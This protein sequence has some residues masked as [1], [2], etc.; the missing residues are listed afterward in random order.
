MSDLHH[1]D[2]LLDDD[3]L[4]AELLLALDA[5]DELDAPPDGAAAPPFDPLHIAR[6]GG[7]SAPLSFAQQ[8]L[9]FFEQ[10]EP[11]TAFFNM[12]VQVRLSGRLDVAAL[13]RALNGIVRRHEALRSVFVM[14]DGAPQQRIAARLELALPLVDLG[15]LAPD[16]REAQARRL[17]RESA[18]QPFDLGRGPL[19]RAGLLRLDAQQHVVMLTMHHIISDGWSMGVLIREIAALYQ[20][21]AEARPAPLPELPVQYAD[22]ARWQRQ[23]LAGGVLEQQLDYWQRQLAGAPPLLALP[24]DRPRPAQQ[25]Y[26]GA[27]WSFVLPP[28]LLRALHALGG[29]HQ[30][31]LFMTLTAA[32]N[33]LLARYSGQNDICL[34]TVIANRERPQTRDLIGFFV[35]TLVLR[36]Q[37]DAS[38]SFA[39]LL[40][41]V[42]ATAL[43]AYAH[44][45]VPFEQLVDALKPVRDAS[46]APLFQVML[47]LQNVPTA[48]LDLPGLS[49][50]PVPAE[51]S[52][53][54]FDLTLYLQEEGG[55][56]AGEFEYN[57]DLFDESS[58]AR[59]A[60]H[61]QYLLGALVADPECAIEQLPLCDFDAMAPVAAVP[62]HGDERPLSPHQ[63]RMWFI[64]V[65]EAG[66]LYPA[67]P[68]YHNIPLLLEVDGP[69]TPQVLQTALDAL[70]ARHA[71]LRT[72]IATREARGWQ[73]IDDSARLPLRLLDA[74]EGGEGGDHAVELALADCA[75]P[76]EMEGGLLVRAALLR[77]GGGANLLAVT[78]HHIIADRASMR[79]LARDLVE[80]CGAA[81]EGRAARLPAL[82]LSHADHAHWQASRDPLHGEALFFYWQ[83]QLRGRLQALELPLNRPRPAV[84]TFTAARH[85]F[86]LDAALVRRLWALAQQC[87]ASR[88]DV[89]ACAF[90]ALMRR[91][92]GHAE[93]VLGTSVPAR[94]AALADT[95]GPLANL[96]VLRNEVGDDSTFLDLLR[97]VA[98]GRAGALRH[99]Q[100]QFDQLALRLKPEKDMSRT[101]LFD[102]L[103]QLEQDG[104]AVLASGPLRARSVE[105]N[106]GYGKNDLHL[107]LHGDGAGLAGKLVYNA[108]FF[109]PW[110]VEQMMGHYVALLEAMAD[111]PAQPVNRVALLDGH[112]RQRQLVDWND[113]AAAYPQELTVHQLFEQQVARLPH[114][115]ALT[116]EDAALSYDAL[117]RRANR[118]AHYLRRQGV[119]AESL[120]ALCLERGVDMIVAMLAVMKAGGAYVPVDP[121]YPAGRIAY[122]LQDSG[123]GW[124]VSGGAALTAL[125]G[126]LPAAMQLVALDAEAGA[127]DGED[128]ANPRNLNAPHHLIYVIYTSGSTGQPKGTLLEHRNVVR[129]LVN[130]R[131]PFSFGARDVWSM[132]HSYAFDFSVWEMYGALLHGGRVALVSASARR[133]PA[134]LLGQLLRQQVSV[135]NQTPTA[136]YNL[137]EEMSRHPGLALPHLRYV[138]FGGEAL[139]A[140]KL[141]AFHAAHPHVALIN[142]YGIT[143]TCVH[144][145]FKRLEGADFDSGASNI[146]RPIPTT[147]TYIMDAGQRLLPAGVAGEICVA[148]LGVG[149]GYLN[150]E[151]LSRQRFVDH[152]CLPGQRLYR[153]G[154]LG[155]LLENGEMVYLGRM[156]KQVQLRGFRVELG[157]IEAAL[158]ALPAVRDVVVCAR[159]DTPGDTRL[160]AYL[161][162]HADATPGDAQALRTALLRTLPD[163][164][165]P[166]HFIVL[167]R[168]PLT[169][170]G[171]VDTRALPAP[172]A[173][174]S[175]H[176]YVAPQT[177][178]EQALAAIW[179]RVLGL[180]QVGAQDNFFALGGHSLLATQVMS[181]LRQTLGVELPLR[182]MFEASSVAAM[183]LRIAEARQQPA[184]SAA[185]P[186][187]LARRDDTPA[188]LSFA[189]Q[190]LWFIDQLGADGALYNVPV[191]MRLTGRLDEV[192]LRRSINEIVRRHAVLRTSFEACDG[193]AVQRIAPQLELALAVTD[194]GLLPEGAREGRAQALAAAE[195]SAPFDLARGP[196][197]RA[198]LLRL[199]ARQHVVLLTLHHGVS[200][201]WS[202]GV[203]VRELAAL[204]AA[205]AAGQPSPLAELALQYADFAQWQR[206]WLDGPVLRRQLDYWRAQLADA[207]ALL[208]LPTDRPRPPQQRHRGATLAFEV[209]PATLQALNQ[210]AQREGATLFML[211]AA[212]FGALLA[213]YSGQSDICIGTPI[214]NRNRAETEQLIGFFVNTL[215]LRTR[216]EPGD[217]YASL[218][219]QVRETALAAYAHQDVP[220]EQLVEALRPQRHLSHTPLFQVMLVLQ[221]APLGSL[222]LPE[223]A[224]A[225]VDN[226]VAVAKFDLTLN[227]AEQDGRLLAAF[228]Y[229]TDLFDAATIERMAGHFTRLLAGAVARPEAP[230]RTL[231]LPGDAERQRLLEEWN[232]APA[233]AATDCAQVLFEAQAAR[234]PQLPALRC[235]ALEL[236]YATLNAS[237]N[238]L[239]RR[240]RALGVGP[241]TLV[242][243]CLE[244][245]ADLIVALLAILKAGGAYVPLDPAYPQERLRHML[246]DAA[247][248]LLLTQRALLP[249]LPLAGLPQ[250]DVLCLDDAVADHWDDGNLVHATL[251]GHL[252]YVIYTSGSSGKPKGVQIAH[253][254]LAA[255][256]AARLACYG[257]GGR[258]LLTSPVSFDS[259][260]AL[261]FGALLGGATLVLT[262]AHSVRDPLLLAGLVERERI[263]MLLCVPSLY[264]ELLHLLD[265]GRHGALRQAIVA[266]EACPPELVRRSHAL[267]PQVGLFNEYGPTEGTVW[268]TVL[269]ATPG[270]AGASVPIGRAIAGARVYILDAA[271]NPAPTGV[272]GELYIGGAG[273]ARAYLR[274]PAMSAEK[275]LPDPYAGQAGARMY[276]SGDLARYLPDG[277]IDYLG[278]LDQ[279]VKIRGFRIELDEIETALAALPGVEA[280]VV[281]AREDSH[282]QRRLVAYLLARQGADAASLAP[283]V[284][285]AA[286]ARSLPDYMVP[287]H[288]VLL[289]QWPL[290]P[291]GKLDRLALPAPDMARE[292]ASLV[293]PATAQEAMLAGL[294]AEVLGL[295]QAG[296][297]DNFFE[298]GG[299]SLLALRLLARLRAVLA[300]PVPLAALFAAPTPRELAA[301][302]ARQEIEDK[303][304][305]IAIDATGEPALLHLGGAPGAPVVFL[306]HDIGGRASAYAGMAAT[307]VRHGYA[308]AALQLT[309]HEAQLPD[310]F[311]VLLARALAAIRQRQ[312]DGPYRLAGHSYGGVLA[313]HVAGRL[314]ALGD[315]VAFLGVLDTVPPEP[316]EVP[317]AAAADPLERCLYIAAA[318]AQVAGAR[319]PAFERAAFAALPDDTARWR[320]I[321]DALAPLGLWLGVDAVAEL[322]ALDRAFA[323]LA[324]LPVAPLPLLRRAPEVWNCAAHAEDFASAWAAS[325]AQPVL[326]HRC[327]GDHVSMLEG[328]SGAALGAALAEAIARG[329]NIVELSG[330][331]A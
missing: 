236:D 126:L 106:L 7:D 180:D 303:L 109:D 260:V 134:L 284:L 331:I 237:A 283:A 201:G 298:L 151:E 50:R 302:L 328:A 17:L 160:A 132:L 10:L 296:A 282:G 195:A 315:R 199:D 142:M 311:E 122:M 268:A 322:A 329:D 245:S 197:I 161:V 65:F 22:Y 159:E 181:Q 92:A 25:R 191:A 186:A 40:R 179:A 210:L 316:G 171:K 169:A 235:G 12:P 158:L 249:A 24:T 58:V 93:I 256:T 269:R 8:R 188:P 214:A 173:N 226:P 63:E 115:V 49:L 167:E 43:G 317:L 301:W 61:F 273:V 312:P 244:R 29:A 293:A 135:L 305:T 97:G 136:F 308:V 221:N 264:A 145:T 266:G 255:S 81:L 4:D 73:R 258:Y 38:A 271:L 44:Q 217:S 52:V 118:L 55:A 232:G 119:G 96:L 13:D 274:Q 211:L 51:R 213:R 112:Q 200:D 123:S 90:N 238:R 187:M 320:L 41:Q 154:D 66:Y 16:E 292:A 231:A 137:V 175:Q 128:D 189:Q 74:G 5:M 310:S 42:R 88:F 79:L 54:K 64:D 152:P 47:L 309:G 18:Q 228:E 208:T 287:A 19:L 31:T 77:Q 172:D 196:L 15:A 206:D 190:R 267:L 105:T 56:L 198:A 265:P 45:D 194:L 32:F 1:D 288:F 176:R 26:Q 124:V 130:E 318:C 207:P 89:V 280:G 140:L 30:A 116:F 60:S 183:A 20:A 321:A 247:P 291:N 234:T 78:A 14:H 224:L 143:E 262:D 285:R 117:N 69:L 107:C 257:H 178:D 242:G 216:I 53:A 204:Y 319:A 23:W 70:M 254:N 86:V 184:A 182:V 162:P 252:A 144:V 174:R 27:S 39:A 84:H 75:L 275:F 2:A 110:L 120:V 149:R 299:H 250:L 131:M 59:M 48:A 246:Q 170:N 98:Q 166:A 21:F 307:L 209:P 270:A 71:I 177:P 286:L 127:I 253:G 263:S 99:Q 223:L 34:G 104:P 240:L 155:K 62:R 102:V 259:S 233:P 281:L 3:L 218:L 6:L 46:H 227:L 272:A 278:R 325:S 146:G 203:L 222:Q 129:L 165:V 83:R 139:N 57:T 241:D 261:I 100:M 33:V 205:F 202:M 80:L 103:F 153:S 193:G 313:A 111:D 91:Y 163:Y 125:D 9:W 212:G 72:R 295:P 304:P 67:S 147:M 230:L 323:L 133:D 326:S 157:E 219:R 37:V 300:Q 297:L 11:G 251:P 215:I 148:G 276:R 36:S 289:A 87:G 114:Q 220:F 35:N 156:D 243:L 330:S 101:A 225:P 327:A 85:A 239:A 95:V 324:R 290:T 113:S 279:Q 82:S 314:E 108:D 192:A 68:T 94:S 164:M 185:E 277:Q 141:K 248:A 229:N 138:I 168:L 76:F 306:L 150:R 121:Q 294:W 28:T